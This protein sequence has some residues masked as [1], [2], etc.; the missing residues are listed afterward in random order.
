MCEKSQKSQ[1]SPEQNGDNVELFRKKNIEVT[2]ITN[3][4]TK[5]YI[6]KKTNKHLLYNNKEKHIN[7]EESKILSL[8][9]KQKQKK[10]KKNVYRFDY[11][12]YYERVRKWKEKRYGHDY[13]KK[14]TITRQEKELPHHT[15]NHH[16]KK[17]NKIVQKNDINK[18]ITIYKNYIGSNDQIITCEEGYKDVVNCVQ[19]YKH[20]EKK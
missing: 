15:K 14:K 17:K 3:N 1:N 10:N 19:Q 7:N 12:K 9:K 5:K 16:Q 2:C 6:K 4:T 13:E 11:I 8:Q 18:N 20:V